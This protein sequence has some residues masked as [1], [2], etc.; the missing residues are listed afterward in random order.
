MPNIIKAVM[1]NTGFEKYINEFK[2]IED[3]FEPIGGGVRQTKTLPVEETEYFL[4]EEFINEVKAKAKGI[5]D[6]IIKKAKKTAQEDAN[7]IFEETRKEAYEEGNQKG[8]SEGYTKGY[9]EAYEKGLKSINQDFDG[10]LCE[11]TEG[12]KALE[13]YKDDLQKSQLKHMKDLVMSIAEKVTCINFESRSDVIQ[14]MIVQ[15]LDKSK[16][17][18]W[19]KIHISGFDSERFFEIQDD[20]IESIKHISEFI[21]VEVMEGAQSG[22]CI[23]EMPDK[24]IDASINTQLE[25]IRNISDSYSD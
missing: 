11:I 13:E 3:T 5:S 7:R 2:D 14:N 12:V 17:S 23:I 21:R 25:N 15:A 1:Q 8:Y 6:K 4:E 18:Q 16:S 20:L 10:I 22:T 24:I 9:V 19:I